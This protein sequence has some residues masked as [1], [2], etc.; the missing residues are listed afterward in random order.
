LITLRPLS[1]ISCTFPLVD[2]GA[3]RRGLGLKQWDRGAHFDC[4][5][6][7]ANLHGRVHANGGL[8]LYFDVVSGYAFESVFST[9]TRIV[10]ESG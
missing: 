2:N 5:A 9:S 6:D 7:I 3:E 10:P 4:L 8:H 1:G